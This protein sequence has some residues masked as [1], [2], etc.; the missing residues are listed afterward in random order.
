MSQSSLANLECSLTD[1]LTDF[2]SKS[3]SSASDASSATQGDISES[4]RCPN[5]LCECSPCLCKDCHCGESSPRE[6]YVQ[7][8]R[9]EPGE[10][11]ARGEHGAPGIQGP[12]GPQGHRGLDGKQG[13]AGPKGEQGIQGPPGPH[14]GK[15]EPGTQGPAGPKGEQGIQGPAGAQGHQGAPGIQGPAG[16]RGEQGPQGPHGP[17]GICRGR[18][19]QRSRVVYVDPNYG[20]DASGVRETEMPFKSLTAALM[21]SQKGDTVYMSGG[22][23]GPMNIRPGRNCVALAPATVSKVYQNNTDTWA[24][25]DMVVLDGITLEADSEPALVVNNYQNIHLKNCTLSSTYTAER[26]STV[27]P[28]ILMSG[29]G[30][31]HVSHCT[32][33]V[34]SDRVADTLTFLQ[35]DNLEGRAVFNDVNA[36]LT[37]RSVDGNLS[38]FHV[39]GPGQL[40]VKNS[41]I[42]MTVLGES[43]QVSVVY[44]ANARPSVV[45]AHNVININRVG[46]ME[47]VVP[48]SNFNYA[49]G[50]TKVLS[51]NNTVLFSPDMKGRRYWEGRCNMGTGVWSNGDMFEGANMPDMMRHPSGQGSYI[52]PMPEAKAS[53]IQP[54]LPKPETKMQRPEGPPDFMAGTHLPEPQTPELNPITLTESAKIAPSQIGHY[55]N[56]YSE[57][58][59]TTTLPT[60]EST[61]P[62]GQRNDFVFVNRSPI[63]QTIQVPGATHPYVLPPSESVVMVYNPLM[64]VVVDSNVAVIE[65]T[66]YIPDGSPK[67]AQMWLV[68]HTMT[69]LREIV[70]VNPNP[71]TYTV[72]AWP[73]DTIN[74]KD[75]Y[76][77]GPHTATTFTQLLGTKGAWGAKSEPLQTPV[78]EETG[79]A[80]DFNQMFPYS[81]LWELASYLGEPSGPET[82]LITTSQN[83]SPEAL[84]TIYF[85]H[86]EPTGPVTV[87]LPEVKMQ[88][89]RT[90]VGIVNSDSTPQTVV[91]NGQP[92]QVGPGLGLLALVTPQ[93]WHVINNIQAIYPGT[94]TL[95]EGLIQTGKIYPAL[96]D[97]QGPI[98]LTNPNAKAYV[99]TAPLG[100]TINSQTTA[101]LPVSGQGQGRINPFDLRRLFPFGLPWPLTQ[102]TNQ[103]PPQVLETSQTLTPSLEN[104]NFALKKPGLTI[105]LPPAASL[106]KKGLGELDGYG[107]VNESSGTETISVGGTSYSL[108][109]GHSLLAAVSG[110]TYKVINNIRDMVGWREEHRFD[111][112]TKQ[113]KGSLYQIPPAASRPQFHLHN[114][115]DYGFTLHAFPGDKIV[116]RPTYTV[117]PN[118]RLKFEALNANSWNVSSA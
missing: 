44:S 97:T 50:S 20:N 79:M 26:K 112:G 110:N 1:P 77:L 10:R 70:V 24:A 98:T 101:T 85:I 80:F 60:V 64:W 9:G 102:L 76:S 8:P 62:I 52:G 55:F 11:G 84:N 43:N 32:L 63:P 114:P 21:A 37:Y 72:S 3:A 54:A 87:T 59:I 103:N 38:A 34:Q 90:G 88:E 71:T 13:S 73:G 96:P 5:P 116:G 94:T 86:S 45:V 41:V 33:K 111:L 91:V 6:K 47:N 117:P 16:P 104:T 107:F 18:C 100:Q 108:P 7:G 113:A 4:S 29:P 58:P 53:R 67:P 30:Q 56:L 12:P 81:S 74:G 75:G 19:S 106:P 14:G 115:N 83:L 36:K 51:Q 118:C 49:R 65:E 66:T 78:E 48:K 46:L 35:A 40:V 92:N 68:G 57:T 25:E 69:S 93:G 42:D 105:T 17:V 39:S 109:S 95:P 28:L 82:G 99:L 22:H 89:T 15:G 31:L 23:Y 27:N 2:S 61:K